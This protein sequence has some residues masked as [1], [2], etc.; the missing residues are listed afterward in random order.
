MIIYR[1][2]VLGRRPGD[3]SGRVNDRVM[4]AASLLLTLLIGCTVLLQLHTSHGHG[5]TQLTCTATHR[6]QHTMTQ[7]ST[8]VIHTHTPL[9][10]RP[11]AAQ[12]SVQA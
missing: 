10:N 12:C 11:T 7:S 2:V 1:N 3:T 6:I 8:R 9:S 5:N 4:V